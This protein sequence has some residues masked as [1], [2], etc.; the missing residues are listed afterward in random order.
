MLTFDSLADRVTRRLR[1]DSRVRRP[2]DIGVEVLPFGYYE[3]PPPKWG[4]AMMFTGT[5]T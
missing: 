2:S 5:A 3:Y 1:L 4:T